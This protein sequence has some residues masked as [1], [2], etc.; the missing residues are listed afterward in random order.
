MQRDQVR[1]QLPGAEARLAAAQELR[2]RLGLIGEGEP[3]HD[4]YVRWKP[5]HEQPIGWDPDLNDGVRLNVRP[6]VTAGVLR[7]KF[8][9]NWKKDRGKDSD[10][11]ERVNDLH[12]TRAE[13]QAAREKAGR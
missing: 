4:I 6:F 2:R 11:S 10:G 8:S 1:K 7:S 9:I 12:Y 5:L 3:P 13:K